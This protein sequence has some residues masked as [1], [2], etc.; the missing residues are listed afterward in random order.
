MDS[1]YRL[2]RELFTDSKYDNISTDAKLLYAMILDRMCLSEKNGW[3]DESGRVYQF[4]TQKEA[5][6]LLRCS[7]N[8]ACSLFAVLENAGLIERR[9]LGLCKAS[10]I[11]LKKCKPRSQN[12]VIQNPKTCDSGLT[13]SLNQ[14]SQKA[15]NNYTEYNQTERNYRNLSIGDD[16]IDAEEIAESVKS[17][18]EY[19]VLAERVDR[20]MLDEIVTLVTEL[21]CIREPIIRIGGKEQPRS[22]VHMRMMMLR[23]EHIEYVI[24]CMEKSSAKIRDIKAYLISALFNAPA[25]MENY[26]NAEVRTDFSDRALKSKGQDFSLI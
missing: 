17:S 15:V 19:D 10:V 9:R 13:N 6:S 23:C 14:E 5:A 8:K 22:L 18:M 1:F 25:T 7:I 21:M 2:P 20:D 11:Y 4:F 24:E 3:H 16:D 12:D 26:Y